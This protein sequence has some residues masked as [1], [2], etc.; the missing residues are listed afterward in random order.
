MTDSKNHKQ[1]YL[2]LRQP[3]ELDQQHG[4][5]A[6]LDHYLRGD[7]DSHHLA[8]IWQNAQIVQV[9]VESKMSHAVATLAPLIQPQSSSGRSVVLGMGIDLR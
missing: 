9:K 8:T 4:G 6:R 2:L 1:N 7:G 3:F 5:R